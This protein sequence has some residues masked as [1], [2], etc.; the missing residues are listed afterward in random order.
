M[1]IAS[2]KNFHQK[3]NKIKNKQKEDKS[4]QNVN[5]SAFNLFI[6]LFCN[7]LFHDAGTCFS[8]SLPKE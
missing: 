5:F 4:S 6:N 7:T 1:Y 8:M 2:I 3:K